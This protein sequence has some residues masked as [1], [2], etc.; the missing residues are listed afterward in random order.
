MKWRA[1]YSSAR[2]VGHA[3]GRGVERV[4]PGEA[5]AGRED[6]S[7]IPPHPD[8]LSL[9]DVNLNRVVE[10]G[11]FDLM[12]GPSSAQIESVPLQVVRR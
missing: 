10:P 11:T 9:L 2:G 3:P 12:V 8:A 1:L 5:E 4:S 6:H 7:R